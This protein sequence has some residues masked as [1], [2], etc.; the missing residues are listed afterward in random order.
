MSTVVTENFAAQCSIPSAGVVNTFVSLVVHALLEAQCEIA[1]S[2]FFPPDYAAQA[3]AYGLEE[4][5]FVIVGAGTAGSVVASRL[6][7]NPKW[8]VLVLEAGGDPPME[9]EVSHLETLLI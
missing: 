6:S 5:D 1:R 8:K 9:S 7:E 3:L 2:D 4:F